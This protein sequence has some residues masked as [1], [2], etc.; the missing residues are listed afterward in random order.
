[1]IRVFYKIDSDRKGV[2]SFSNLAG[3]QMFAEWVEGEGGKARVEE[4][5]ATD[6]FDLLSR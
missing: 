2:T 4:P 5:E 1:M 6:L 3:A